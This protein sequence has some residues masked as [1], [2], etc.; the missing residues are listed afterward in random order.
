MQPAPSGGA[1]KKNDQIMQ[2]PTKTQHRVWGIPWAVM[3]TTRDYCRYTT[4][5]LLPYEGAIT[6]GGIDL[7]QTIVCTSEFLQRFATRSGG[8]FHTTSSSIGIISVSFF[9]RAWGPHL[10]HNIGGC[11][12]YGPF[13]DIRHLIF[14]V[15]KKGP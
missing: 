1:P 14:R 4:A 2:G 15:P 11:Q 12:N 6:T 10:Y 9:S 7:R 5:L 3:G 8:Y 13:L